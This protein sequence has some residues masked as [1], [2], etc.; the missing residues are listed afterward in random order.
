MSVK[1]RLQRYGR[2]KLPF[3]RMV[4]ADIQKPRD[5]RFIELVGTFNPLTDPETVTI[6]EERIKHWV[7]LG[8][9]PSDRVASI[10]NKLLPDYLGDIEKAQL[11]KVRSKRAKRKAKLAG[12][13]PVKSEAKLKRRARAQREKPEPVVKKEE[14]PAEEAAAAE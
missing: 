14:A 8:A 13:K 3:Y 2:K 1:I 6:K 11:E 5:G 7:A 4:V 10:L 12:K 9:R